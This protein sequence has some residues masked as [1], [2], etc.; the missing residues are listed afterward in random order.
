MGNSRFFSVGIGFLIALASFDA[1][2]LPG[3][4]LS[5]ADLSL[6]IAIMALGFHASTIR[7][8]AFFWGVMVPIILLINSAIFLFHEALSNSAYAD[9]SLLISGFLRP[10]F[11]TTIAI[12]FYGMLRDRLLT[13]SDIERS[14]Q[15]AGL[16]LSVVVALQYFKLFPLMYHNNPSFGESGRFTVFAEG[17]RPTGLTNEASFVG[18]FLF[19]LFV[20]SI[21][22][23][24]DG[25]S[26]PGYREF[27]PP[28]IVFV[29]CLLSTSRISLALSVAFV[30]FRKPSAKRL[31]LI[32]LAVPLLLPY[33]DMTRL[34]NMMVFNGDASTIERYGSF[35]AY[36]G[37]LTDA[38]N[39]FGTGYLNS[40]SMVM[41]YADPLL[42]KVLGDRSLPAF[43]L[44]L[45]LMVELGPGMFL[46]LVLI[47]MM[48]YRKQIFDV[49]IIAVFAAAAVTGVQNFLFVYIYIAVV[50]YERNS[51]SA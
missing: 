48:K 14:I 46:L 27:V 26:S 32:L 19:L 11:F 38:S 6:L 37:A 45:Q 4:R 29:G 30:I 35:F 10:I 41:R 16:V 50:V 8:A 47:G 43:S 44:P 18:I 49:R 9:Y 12:F 24:R 20:A 42:L 22:R 17:W 5:V 7:A 13:K 28:A 39:F 51:R 23:P 33:V 34:E 21:A 36:I 3:I 1:I 31:A 15:V 2:V 25:D 40:T